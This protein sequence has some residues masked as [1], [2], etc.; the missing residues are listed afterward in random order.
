MKKPASFICLF[1]L[2]CNKESGTSD[3]DGVR[4]LG[5]NEVEWGISASGLR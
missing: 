4:K 5:E 2:L 1:G 3:Y